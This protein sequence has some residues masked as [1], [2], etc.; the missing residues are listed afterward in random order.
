M[1]LLGDLDPHRFKY[2]VGPDFEALPDRVP[3]PMLG[4][5]ATM[6]N[7]DKWFCNCQDVPVSVV[8]ASVAVGNH[9]RDSIRRDIGVTLGCCRHRIA[10]LVA[11]LQAQQK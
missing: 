11:E 9:D 10:N 4:G 2:P 7:P 3:D 5:D 1:G 6:P 8:K